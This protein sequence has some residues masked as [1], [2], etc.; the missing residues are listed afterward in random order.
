MKEI[1]IIEEAYH[2]MQKSPRKFIIEFHLGDYRLSLDN[3]DIND[4]MSEE[5]LC[6]SADLVFN[7][8]VVGIC[9]NR[10]CGGIAEYDLYKYNEDF[11]EFS[12]KV[13]EIVDYAFPRQTLNDCSVIDS[14]ACFSAAFKDNNVTTIAKAKALINMWNEEAEK[15]H[16]QFS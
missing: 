15:Y 11:K 6:F 12:Y 1:G 2:V 13:R 3:I 10:G 14:L 8:E 5:T 4:R 9:S 7:G 16:E